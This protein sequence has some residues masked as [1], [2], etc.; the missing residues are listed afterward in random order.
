M[1]DPQDIDIPSDAELVELE[2]A[3]RVSSAEIQRRIKIQRLRVAGMSTVAIADRMQ[4][5]AYEVEQELRRAVQ[6]A[7]SASIDEMVGTQ[8][9]ILTDLLRVN[10]PLALQGD[11]PA[12]DRVLRLLARQSQLYGLDAPNRVHIG[13]SDRDFNAVATRLVEQIAAAPQIVDVDVV[14]PSYTPMFSELAADEG[15]NL[16]GLPDPGR[17]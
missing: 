11:G 13:V 9:S 7:N 12:T 1:S 14:E 16:L 17:G 5:R 2:R 6:D 10:Y 15:V 3:S 4:M 8:N